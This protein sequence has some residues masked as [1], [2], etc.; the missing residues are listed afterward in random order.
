ALPEI[1]RHEE[2]G[3]LV[4]PLNEERLAEAVF[5]LLA[6]PGRRQ[7]MGEMGRGRVKRH[8]SIR[9]TV[10]GVEEIYR[11]WIPG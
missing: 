5:S 7:M 10:T 1:V 11:A 6:D 4:T 2:T 8:F 9:Q 3:L